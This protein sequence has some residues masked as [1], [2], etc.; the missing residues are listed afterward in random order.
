[1]MMWRQ[2]QDKIVSLPDQKLASQL[3]VEEIGVAVVAAAVYYVVLF[4]YRFLIVAVG[5]DSY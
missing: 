3:V 5:V 2:P 1:M 4:H